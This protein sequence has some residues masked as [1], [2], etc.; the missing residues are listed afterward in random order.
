MQDIR[1]G[2]EKADQSYSVPC[3]WQP[4]ALQ[5]AS[6]VRN[7]VISGDLKICSGSIVISNCG[8]PDMRRWLLVN[9]REIDYEILVGGDNTNFRDWRFWFQTGNLLANNCGKTLLLHFVVVVVVDDLVVV[10][11]LWQGQ[12]T[13]RQRR[14]H[15]QA[16]TIAGPW[17]PCNAGVSSHLCGRIVSCWCWICIVTGSL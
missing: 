5:A 15:S 8:D 3:S 13:H 14:I 17:L 2:K 9:C 6:L 11:G 12:K 16:G 7:V 10:L 1:W 4:P